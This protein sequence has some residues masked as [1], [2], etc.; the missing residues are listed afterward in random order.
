M[1]HLYCFQEIHVSDYPE[2]KISKQRNFLK[3]ILMSVSRIVIVLS[4]PATM[5]FIL[6]S[7]EGILKTQLLTNYKPGQIAYQLK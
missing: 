1:W 5:I 6:K 2:Q 3:P 4:K 7:C